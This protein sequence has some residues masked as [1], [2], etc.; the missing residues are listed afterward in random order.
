MDT[1]NRF[2]KYQEADVLEKGTV[3]SSS[4]EVV[5]DFGKKKKVPS[6]KNAPKTIRVSSEDAAGYKMAAAFK[7]VTMTQLASD[8]LEHYLNSKLLSHAQIAA[9]R[10]AMK[11]AADREE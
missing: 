10:E 2:A 1:E 11:S 7:G 9:V 6:N 5:L 4:E 3:K 8:A